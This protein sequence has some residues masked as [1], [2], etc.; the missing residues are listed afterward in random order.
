MRFALRR[1]SAIVLGW[2]WGRAQSHGS[3]LLF[4]PFTACCTSMGQ[5]RR[6]CP[7]KASL[8]FVAAPLLILVIRAARNSVRSWK[9]SKPLIFE[10]SWPI[11]STTSPR[12]ARTRAS[13]PAEGKEFYRTFAEPRSE[14]HCSATARDPP[15][16]P[17]RARP[18]GELPP[19]SHLHLHLCVWALFYLGQ[20]LHTTRRT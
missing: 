18:R 3:Y 7:K 4:P 16:W 8:E 1:A 11:Y 2:E 15:R 17:E 6:K 9:E 19:L 14:R 12:C 13:E 5:K 10:T 20:V